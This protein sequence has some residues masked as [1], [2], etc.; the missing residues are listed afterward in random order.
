MIGRG[1]LQY[2]SFS[3]PFTLSEKEMATGSEG[4][5]QTLSPYGDLGGR[6]R[7][8]ERRKEGG[9]EEGRKGKREGRG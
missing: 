5:K 7:E 3:L 6:E 4:V 1:V 8:G 9:V 2:L